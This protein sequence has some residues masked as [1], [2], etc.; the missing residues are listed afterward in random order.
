MEIKQGD[1]LM[2]LL[3]KLEHSRQQLALMEALFCQTHDVVEINQDACRGLVTTLSDVREVLNGVENQMRTVSVR[4]APH[5]RL[6][7]ADG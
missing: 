4:A 3:D 5:V 1:V 6:P 7:V 2:Y